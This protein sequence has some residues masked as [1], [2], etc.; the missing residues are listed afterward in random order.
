MRTFA[1][2][3][4]LSLTPCVALHAAETNAP[5]LESREVMTASRFKQIVQL[6]GDPTP[7]TARLALVPFW[8]NAIASN[9]MTYAEGRVFRETMTQRART[10]EG[11]YIVFTVNSE[12]YNQPMN[13]IVT[14]DDK[15]ATLKTYG[16]YGN[17]HGAD[18]LTEGVVTIDVSKKTYLIKSAYGEGFKETTTG[19][20][21]D[22]E[23]TARTVV[24]RNGAL[25]MTRKVVTH[26][27]L[28]SIEKPSR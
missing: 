18:L 26:P 17:G 20:C 1:I 11:K 4:L 15:A 14:Y 19:V 27:V 25:F 7:L 3:L 23:D 24:H 12:F 9:V 2:I 5:S 22:R 10:V 13:S 28:D 6:P 21:S 16:L 8:T